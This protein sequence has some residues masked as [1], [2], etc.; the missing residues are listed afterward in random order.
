MAEEERNRAAEE[1]EKREKDIKDSEY[2]LN[3][4]LFI[5]G[6]YLSCSTEI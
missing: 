3:S 2:G 4:F 5:A 1:L 6:L